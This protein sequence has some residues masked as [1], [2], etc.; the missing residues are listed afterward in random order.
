MAV[1]AGMRLCRQRMG[2]SG[3]LHSQLSYQTLRASNRDCQ[4]S[5]QISIRSASDEDAV[6]L[7]RIYNH[8]VSNTVV[9]FETELVAPQ[10][11]AERIAETDAIPLPWLVAETAGEI[12]G[13][14]YA[15]EWKGRCAYRFSVETTI[16]LDVQHTAKGMGTSLYSALVDSIRKSSLHSMIGAIALP[17]A[18]SI[19]IVAEKA[20][21]AAGAKGGRTK[22]QS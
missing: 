1:Q 4:V 10:A 18:A 20:A 21:N 6:Q 14:A 5:M 11:M 3:D 13:Y 8:Y 12:L 9:T 17:N 2:M 7:A 19:T 16:Y 15:S 22:E